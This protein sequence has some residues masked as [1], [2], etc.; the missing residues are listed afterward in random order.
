MA[1][2]REE[3][4]WS[5]IYQI[6]EQDVVQGGPEGI[7]NVPHKDLANRTVYLKTR[8]E[9]LQARSSGLKN[10]IVNGD[11]SVWGEGK[12]FS[13]NLAGKIASRW[14]QELPTVTGKIEQSDEAPL[15][16]SKSLHLYGSDKATKLRQLLVNAADILEGKIVTVSAHFRIASGEV[17]VSIGDT[18]GSVILTEHDVWHRV[19]FT[20]DSLGNTEAFKPDAFMDID[21]S[22]GCDFFVTGVQVEE[23]A[24]VTNYEH[25]PSFLEMAKCGVSPDTITSDTILV[26]NSKELLAALRKLKGKQLGLGVK[27]KLADGNY[28]VN[29]QILLENRVRAGELT[30]EGNLNDM[31]KVQIV[32][33][34]PDT[35]AGITLKNYS[36]VSLGIWYKGNNS[37]RGIFTTED[38]TFSQRGGQNLFS[39]FDIAVSASFRTKVLLQ[40]S[41]FNKNRVA[42]SA[43]TS[44][45]LNLK[46]IRIEG[47]DPVKVN[48]RGVLLSDDCY[49]YMDDALVQK[50]EIG[51]SV[52]GNSKLSVERCIVLGCTRVHIVAGEK[53][54]ILLSDTTIDGDSLGGFGIM[55]R[56]GGEVYASEGVLVGNCKIGCSASSSSLVFAPAIKMNNNDTSF[57]ISGN[58]YMFLRGAYSKSLGIHFVMDGGEVDAEK[59]N[60]YGATRSFATV[61]N[62]AKADFSYVN[63]RG[64][65]HV[66]LSGM[67]YCVGYGS[68]LKF[69][70]P[71]N[72]IQLAGVIR[73]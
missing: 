72:T 51:M 21:G 38:S 40:G 1:T 25:L 70:V 4:A 6:E 55:L 44:C 11:F 31:K 49:A 34:T 48:S 14:E 59:M 13:G 57:S 7:D 54:F 5:P 36:L 73:K 53:G 26:E 63:D 35:L 18:G 17:K 64:S 69:N 42:I 43:T 12:F 2:I 10:F 29:E 39:N 9:E 28:V 65:K 52:Y 61:G 45:F 56:T 50:V 16:F 22:S 58:S 8:M 15:G 24:R 62:Q 67:S 66:V 47:A 71:I 41:I 19:S 23:G 32:F 68:N 37:N 20:T 60:A 46:S 27:I 30:L 33:S 3:N